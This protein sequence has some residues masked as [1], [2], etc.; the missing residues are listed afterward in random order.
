V[1]RGFQNSAEWAVFN[2]I[3]FKQIMVNDV[4][5]PTKNRHFIVAGDA[6][7]PLK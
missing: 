7:Q 6:V 4:K 1:V 2:H 5:A 3:K